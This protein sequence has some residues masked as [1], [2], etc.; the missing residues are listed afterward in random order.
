MT[1]NNSTTINI[2][3][4]LF[5]IWKSYIIST[6]NPR[7]QCL[8]RGRKI[9]CATYH[10]ET[11][12]F[13]T[14]QRKFYRKFNLTIIHRKAKFIVGYTNVNPKG[15][16]PTSTRRQKIPYLAGTWLQDILSMWMQWEILSKGVRKSPHQRRSP[17]L[18]LKRALLDKVN[19][20]LP[21]S[22]G[23]NFLKWY[24]SF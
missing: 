6:I 8:E 20:F 24:D 15:Q 23:L 3:L 19:Q 16:L 7:S 11:K 1:A 18:G 21:L 10:F 22:S 4:F 12:S 13:K 14:V 5:Q 9:F 17:E 2:V